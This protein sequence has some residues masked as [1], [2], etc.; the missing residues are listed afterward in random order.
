MARAAWQTASEGRVTGVKRYQQLLSHQPMLYFLSKACPEIAWC[1][2]TLLHRPC[3]L[4]RYHKH[5]PLYFDDGSSQHV[6]PHR[7]E[8]QARQK[9]YI[10]R[11]F[12]GTALLFIVIFNLNGIFIV[13]V[14]LQ[15]WRVVWLK[16]VT[17]WSN[18]PHV[19]WGIKCSDGSNIFQSGYVISIYIHL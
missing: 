4:M 12:F 11:S 17:N 14:I 3:Y 19:T 8:E 15:W 2:Q 7:M 10:L 6:C 9:S 1:D 18:G 16:T 13:V 5:H